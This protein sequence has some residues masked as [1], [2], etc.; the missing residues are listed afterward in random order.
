VILLK[1]VLM[2]VAT[3]GRMAPAEFRDI[4]ATAESAVLKI[5]VGQKAGLRK[6]TRSPG[7][8]TGWRRG[9][10]VSQKPSSTGAFARGVRPRSGDS[11]RRGNAVTCSRPRQG[12][13][14]K[15]AA[16]D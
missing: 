4:T 2:L 6:R 14:S 15:R 9:S 8:S 13:T 5:M 11:V 7:G 16:G 1:I 12:R 3:G 10:G